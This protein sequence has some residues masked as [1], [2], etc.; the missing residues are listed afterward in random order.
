M[1]KSI[2][3]I[4]PSKEYFKYVLSVLKKNSKSE[5]LIIYVTANKSYGELSDYLKKEGMDTRK[6]F[7]I[8]CVSNDVDAKDDIENCLFL[9]TPEQ[10]TGISLAIN[11]TMKSMPGKKI[12]LIDSLSI[13][14][15]Y[16]TESV[17]GKFSNFIMRR[18]RITNVSSAFFVLKS[19]SKKKI[20]KTIESFADEVK[21]WN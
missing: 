5:N 16:N 18:A 7:F 15:V 2:L 9:Q 11:K 8:D 4:T 20:I 21:E 17:V 12:L 10:I 6:F 13:L 1:V 14:L 19:D 3:Y